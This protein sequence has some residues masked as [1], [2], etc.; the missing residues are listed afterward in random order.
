MLHSVPAVFAQL[1]AVLP[2][3][4][5]A[6]R[7]S[8]MLEALPRDAAPPVAQ[9]KL[10]AMRTVASSRL[11]Q[12]QGQSPPPPPPRRYDTRGLWAVLST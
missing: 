2:D 11:F 3:I 7:L 9:A 4:E 12:D 6:R 8:L 10:T 5:I 1:R